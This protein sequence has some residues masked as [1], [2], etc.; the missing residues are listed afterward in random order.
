VDAQ[1]QLRL[2]EPLP[3]AGPSR[4]RVIILLPEAGDGEEKAWAKA[5]ATSPAFEFLKDPAEDVYARADGKPFH[6]QR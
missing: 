6:D 4:V 5:A 1:H 3:L 2:D